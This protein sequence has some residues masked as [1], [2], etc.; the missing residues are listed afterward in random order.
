M[1]VFSLAAAATMSAWCSQADFRLGLLSAPLMD[2]PQVTRKVNDG[3]LAA[4]HWTPL[5]SSLLFTVECFE[6]VLGFASLCG[7]CRKLVVRFM[8]FV[9]QC[10]G[11]L[12]VN[13][14]LRGWKDFLL[15]V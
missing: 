11:S 12:V 3:D 10:Y 15:D 7:S 1:V 2:L 4:I 14:L 6:F 9:F 5:H 8:E 13:R